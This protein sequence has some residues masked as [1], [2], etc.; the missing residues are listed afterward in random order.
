[1]NTT[2]SI[3][4]KK[5]QAL[6]WQ[7]K[8]TKLRNIANRAQK[9]ADWMT[10]LIGQYED[11]IERYTGEEYETHPEKLQAYIEDC[12]K[13]RA[14]KQ[15]RAELAVTEMLIIAIENDDPRVRHLAK[16]TL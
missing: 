13:Q 7:V 3:L 5:D 1:M 9:N 12:V 10:T 14:A 16:R 4:S 2:K 8:I 15:A 11:Q 6:P